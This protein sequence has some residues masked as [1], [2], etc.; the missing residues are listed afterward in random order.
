MSNDYLWD[1]TGQRDPEVERLEKLLG[2][3]GYK[4]APADF[5]RRADNVREMRPRRWLAPLATAAAALL[6]I[7]SGGLW[8]V[9]RAAAWDVETLTGTPRIGEQ[10]IADKGQLPVGSYLETDASSRARVTV[11]LIG[12]VNVEPNTRLGLL[13]AAA[14]HNRMT[15]ERGTIHAR[16]WAP[17]RLFYVQTPAALAVDLGCRY[18]LSVD[19]S[20]AGQLLVTKGWVAFEL[21]GRE[22]FVPEGAMCSTRPK[23]G[24]GTPYFEDA[25]SD[26]REA[27]RQLDFEL[28]A[29][30]GGISGGVTGGITG[31]VSG[32]PAGGVIGGPE[33]GIDG[34]KR[35]RAAALQTLL[36]ESRK[37]DSLTLWHLLTRV[38]PQERRA[39]Y[40]ALARLVPPPDSVT[41]D[42]IARGDRE[43]LDD[44]WGALD[45][46]GA[47]FWRLWKQPP[48]DFPR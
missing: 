7:A 36:G 15:L 23:V 13:N 18:T 32:G 20:G 46:K 19:P 30:A 8:Y 24:P 3:F 6:V 38:L 35:Q 47:G 41:P 34:I 4:D 17:P 40:D 12:V 31:G 10:Q 27:L 21:D 43:M 44:W 28:G 37:R 26:F 29:P 25:S 16:I 11:G 5:L 2:E 45:A 14:T 42:G 39:V 9:T 33:G 48:P 1:R 22:S